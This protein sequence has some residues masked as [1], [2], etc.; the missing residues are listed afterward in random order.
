MVKGRFSLAVAIATAIFGA[1]NVARAADTPVTWVGTTADMTLGT[2][3]STGAVPIASAGSSTGSAVT[4][5]D[6]GNHSPVMDGP[7]TIKTA[8]FDNTITSAYN[9][10]GTGTWTAGNASN[11]PYISNASNADVTIDVAQIEM[12]RASRLIAGDWTASPADA[13][14]GDLTIGSNGGPMV[15]KMGLGAATSASYVAAS[16]DNNSNAVVVTI[17][18]KL[19]FSGNTSSGSNSS[20]GSGNNVALIPG[21]LSTIKL[22]GGITGGATP[23]GGNPSKR[24]HT[25]GAFGGKT[26][27]GDSTGWLGI[28][29]LNVSDLEINSNNSL[30]EAGSDAAS[31][32]WIFGG[33]ST[34]ALRL[35]NDI[36]SGEFFYITCRTTADVPLIRNISGSNT[37][38]GELVD[39]NNINGFT[40]FSSD[41]TASGDLIKIEGNITRTGPGN[42]SS[43]VLTGA[44]DGWISGQITQTTG[45]WS[46]LQKTG[47]GS[48]TLSGANSYTGTTT[49]SD[50][51]LVVNG[52]H[53]GGGLYTVEA[54][55]IL[56]GTSTNLAANLVVNGTFE[57][58]NSIGT[59]TINGDVDLNGILAVEYDSDFSTIDL[60][61]V[62]GEF[63]LTGGTFNFSDLG[64][65]S[66]SLTPHVFATY[67]T[68]VGNPA[69]EVGVPVGFVVNYAFSGN[70]IALVP[71]PEPSGIVL[72]SFAAIGLGAFGRKRQS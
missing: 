35:T 55:A 20:N 11:L 56:A 7:M 18:P 39:D 48:W 53:T 57:P 27:L 36:T 32:T 24:L 50:G 68:L 29:Q 40:V 5:S 8:F 71:V 25:E 23:T 70:Q 17:Y 60:L 52:T 66:L 10:T 42:N 58:G 6:A 37:L 34:G 63:D 12:F 65:G 3:W 1:A 45:I 49:V 2:N 47:D 38:T 4:F 69:L 43:L 51:T 26:I 14:T 72:L 33:A 54:G 13:G 9:I 19:D 59:F 28:A 61:N 44:G 67:G 30:G 64:S 15:L 21:A 62:T 16:S 22:L 46:S 31:Y 41:G